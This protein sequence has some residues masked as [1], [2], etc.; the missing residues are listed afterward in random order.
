MN[1][2]DFIKKHTDTV[3]II[4]LF[5]ICYFLFF[6]NMGTYPLID[7][8]ETRYVSIARDMFHTHDFLN[9]KLNEVY[10]FEKPPLYFWLLNISFFIFGKVN[11][12]SARFPIALI[13]SIAVFAVYFFGRK[14]ISQAY[15]LV[16]A[17]IMA[18]S[19]EF[20]V[21]GRISILD[22]LLSAFILFAV[23]TGFMTFFCEEKNKKYFW[24][25]FYILSG[26]AALS[27]GIPGA[28]VPILTI[29]A[30]YLISG[31]IKEF[32]KPL[33]FIPGIIIFLLVV[34]PWHIIMLNQH[35]D[36]FYQ[37]YIYK[38]HL[39]RF[40]NSNELGRKEPWYFFIV[41]FIVAFIP[42][43]TSFT[44]MLFDKTKDFINEVSNYFKDFKY[45]A[46]QEKWSKLSNIQKV[47]TLNFIFFIAV[48]LFFS[49]SSTKLPTY[50]LP[51]L[52][53]AA[54]LLAYYWTEYIN[55]GKYDKKIAI[56]SFII[57][58]LLIIGSIGGVFSQF[59]LKNDIQSYINHFRISAILLC[60]IVAI[61]GIFAVI[62]KQR[63]LVFFTFIVLM[64]GTMMI[65]ANHIFDVICDFGQNDLI[66]FA[67]KAKKDKVKLATFD[68][69]KKYS[70]IYYYE[71]SVDFQTE[72]KTDWFKR[73]F[74]QNPNAYIIV[75]L[76]NMEEL[77]K[78]L[79]YTVVD[80]GTK[81]ALIKKN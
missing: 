2:L 62:L 27:K 66:E 45:S 44:A 19:F 31:K 53:A 9:L 20:L 72:N 34:L 28:A 29:G 73:Y 40:I 35:G 39:E 23:L 16:S 4:F 68:F 30:S 81:Y 3:S 1:I 60:F 70:V 33:Y 38:H 71:D 65:S 52:P 57:Y 36:L 59:F 78:S 25:G 24:W 42:W 69:G 67:Q 54:M 8:D 46:L 75:K 18:T 63:R 17:L 43:I 21:L 51:A 76:K 15:G 47:L 32:F 37:E 48:F 5:L 14:V 10:F 6:Y 26:F 58:G 77:D 64:T 56:S 50:L 74:A 41:V 22:M 55:N 11:E 12:I 13:S 7:V 80:T 79:K 49:I 61:T